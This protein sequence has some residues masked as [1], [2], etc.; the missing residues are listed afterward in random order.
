LPLRLL[1]ALPALRRI[2]GRAIALGIRHEKVSL[3]LAA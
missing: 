1:E 2:P 3:P